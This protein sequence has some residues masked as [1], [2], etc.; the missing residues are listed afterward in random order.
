VFAPTKQ[1]LAG[2]TVLPSAGFDT[3]MQSA[4]AQ[5]FGKGAL[6]ISRELKYVLPCHALS[7]FPYKLCFVN[8][9]ICGNFVCAMTAC[10]C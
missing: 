9:G 7:V 10:G 1:R 2:V 3:N 8:L 5:T 4:H 6:G